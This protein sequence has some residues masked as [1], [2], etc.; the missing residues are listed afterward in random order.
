M[1]E[2]LCTDINDMTFYIGEWVKEFLVD[3]GDYITFWVSSV[4]NEL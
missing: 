4:N 1:F 3:E 2:T